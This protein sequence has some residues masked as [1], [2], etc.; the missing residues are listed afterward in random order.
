MSATPDGKDTRP[1]CVKSER[2]GLPYAGEISS[3]PRN[4]KGRWDRRKVVADRVADSLGRAVL[5][6][7]DA[8]SVGPGDGVARKNNAGGASLVVE[9]T[10]TVWIGTLA[11]GDFCF[12]VILD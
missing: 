2:T 12:I 11:E 1:T 3:A 9:T 6:A 4:I 8:R 10:R 5:V 7:T